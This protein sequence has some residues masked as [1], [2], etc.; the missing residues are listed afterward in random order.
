MAFRLQRQ[1]SASLINSDNATVEEDLGRGWGLPS[2]PGP[3]KATGWAVRQFLTLRGPSGVL[4]EAGRRLLCYLSAGQGRGRTEKAFLLTLSLLRRQEITAIP[5]Q[6]GEEGSC[7]HRGDTGVLFNDIMA[8]SR[9]GQ[10]RG[11][12]AGYKRGKRRESHLLLLAEHSKRSLGPS[13][14]K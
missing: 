1:P 14:G 9:W 13:A 8:K 12:R 5:W 7:S 6:S 10:A 3:G 2:P 11:R 4:S